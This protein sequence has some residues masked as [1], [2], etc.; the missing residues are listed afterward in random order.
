MIGRRY[1]H[2]EKMVFPKI[3]KEGMFTIGDKIGNGSFGDVFMAKKRDG[4]MVAIKFEPIDAK[5]NICKMKS[6]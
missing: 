6:R 3:I 5:K 4:K 1:Q 2:K